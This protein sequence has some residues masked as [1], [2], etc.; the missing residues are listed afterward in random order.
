[1]KK[2]FAFVILLFLIFDCSKKPI[3]KP[4]ILS[5]D[6]KIKALEWGDHNVCVSL[7]LNFD[8]QDI[9]R[10]KLYW[11]CR[12]V[13]AKYHLKPRGSIVY[14]Q[15]FNDEIVNLVTQ[16]SL[17]LANDSTENL[18]SQNKKLDN[19]H[20][21]RCLKLG[22]DFESDD[23]KKIEEYF[24]CRKALID[25]YSL[26]NPY[27]NDEYARYKNETY[28]L[29]FVV[30]EAVK[31]RVE[32]FN[33]FK[34]KYPYCSKFKISSQ[35]F[36]N[37][38]QAVDSNA[39]CVSKIAEKLYQKDSEEKI[40]CQK[41]AYEKYGDEL[42]LDF[43]KKQQEIIK[44][45]FIAD[46]VNRNNLESLGLNA[47]MFSVESEEKLAEKNSLEDD[48]KSQKQRREKINSRTALYS[49]SEITHLRRS[50]ISSCQK[51]FNKKIQQY[52]QQLIVDCES[53]LEFDEIEE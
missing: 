18:Y 13:F 41:K 27:G 21:Q 49:K 44:D 11:R 33:S 7:K 38:Q 43:D 40:I 50:F 23:S 28:D 42:L 52:H 51:I 32:K 9:N 24:T 4:F 29:S 2:I 25:E 12:L 22:Y 47:K 3:D 8:S 5:V 15:D 1:M 10:S 19:F 31:K 37:C 53:K 30:D 34:E 6:N 17:K 36:K 26:S 46:S 48:K 39:S 35:N 14:N 20:H 16:I 45:N